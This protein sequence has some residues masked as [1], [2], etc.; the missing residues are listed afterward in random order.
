MSVGFKK[1]KKKNKIN[2]LMAQTTPD[3]LFGPVYVAATPLIVYFVD[4][5]YIYTKH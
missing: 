1:M 4:Y 2:S 5:I 3:V